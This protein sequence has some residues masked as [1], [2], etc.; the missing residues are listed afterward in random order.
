MMRRYLVRNPNAGRNTPGLRR[1]R[2]LISRNGVAV[3][4]YS[5]CPMYAAAFASLAL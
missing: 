4:R 1:L 5:S 3:M 2:A